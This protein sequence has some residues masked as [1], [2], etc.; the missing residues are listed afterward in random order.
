MLKSLITAI[1]AT[2]LAATPVAAQTNANFTGPRVELN[3]GFDDLRGAHEVNDLTYGVTTGTDF[4]L[5]DR[6]TLGGEATASNFFDSEGRELGAGVRLGFAVTP[7]VLTYGRVGYST[8]DLR[9]RNVD[10]LNVGGGLNFAITP[11]LYTGVEYR[12][13]DF[14]H[15]VG[16]HGARVALGLRL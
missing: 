8:V 7:R 10:G 9:H 3:A 5:G 16:S 1:A 13:S 14:E 2:A 12:Y 15:N 6:F 4:A 11:N